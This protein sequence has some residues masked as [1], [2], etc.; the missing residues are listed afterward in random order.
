MTKHALFPQTELAPGELRQVKVDGVAIVV[1]RT[2]DG[3][4]RALR[5]TCPH[6]GALLS[7]GSLEAAVDGPDVGRYELSPDRAVLRCPWHG[8][9]FDVESGR[10]LADPG[11][12][13]RAYLVTVEA[14]IV[15]VER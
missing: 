6:Q 3:H 2:S 11:S 4:L 15:T 12:R 14:G 7:N 8:Y 5:D 13:V 10:C 9:E 1:L